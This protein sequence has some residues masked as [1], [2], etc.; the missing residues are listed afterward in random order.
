MIVAGCDVGSLSA[1]AVIMRDGSILS[2]Q[3]MR[4]R[5]RPEQSA[6]EVMDRALSEAGLGYGDVDCC[7]STG[8][9]RE[10][11]PFAS[12]NISEISCHGRGAHW[13]CPTV[14]TVI[15]VGGQDCKVVRVD[16]NGKL[17]NFAMN[18]KC[19]AGTGR[20]L[21]FMAEV[22]GLGIEELGPSGLSSQQP[23]A[24]TNMCSIF[25]ES[26]ILYYRWYEDRDPMDLAA[27]INRAMAERVNALVQRVGAEQDVCVTGGVA[28]NA[29]VV[30]ALEEML[31]VNS[32][33]LA[34]DPQLVGAV[35]ACLFARD[36]LSKSGG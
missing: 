12:N 32:Q 23:I 7:V 34:V 13:L 6:S 21:E 5:P 36:H 20:F 3:I 17:M 30:H 11:I 28:K 2:S 8:Y 27:G 16:G 26:E 31:Q 22:L 18:D 15:D 10:K 14:R 9:G 35:G 29:G 25:A 33:V 1:E 24:I 19:A 4:V